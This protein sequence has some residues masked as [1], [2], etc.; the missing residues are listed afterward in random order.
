MSEVP[1]IPYPYDAN[2]LPLVAS[3]LLSALSDVIDEA[4]GGPGAEGATPIRT[5]AGGIFVW[6]AM[7]PLGVGDAEIGLNFIVE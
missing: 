6:S 3:D 7:Q 5:Y 4:S 1:Y 2:N